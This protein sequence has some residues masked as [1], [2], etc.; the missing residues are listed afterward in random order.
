MHPEEYLPLVTVGGLVVANDGD[1]LLLRSNKWKDHYHAP[2]GQ[3]AL[4]EKRED[5][6]FR[7]VKEATCLDVINVQYVLTIDSIF[8]DE[9]WK[10]SH[11][12]MHEY[13]SSLSD[14]QDKTDV[15]LNDEINDFVWVPPAQAQKLPLTK[16]TKILLN[17]LLK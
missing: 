7:E 15:M 14:L 17:W 9:F 5:A 1:I 6:F 4:G 8:S 16:E 12:V 13:T 10:K 3:V 2:C 11:F